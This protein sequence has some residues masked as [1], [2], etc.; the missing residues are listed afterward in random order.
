MRSTEMRNMNATLLLI[1]GSL[2]AT[3]SAAQNTKLSGV[4]SVRSGTPLNGVRVKVKDSNGKAVL[5]MAVTNSRG[6]Y[7]SVVGPGSLVIECEASDGNPYA[8]NPVTEHVVIP[9]NVKS[10]RQDCFFDPVVTTD[11]YWK[12]VGVRIEALAAKNPDK[13]SFYTLQWNDIESANL[14]PSSKAAAAH[15]FMTM[16][17]SSKVNSAMFSD[18]GKVDKF[19]LENAL[20]GDKRALSDLPDSVGKEVL[21][22]KSHGDNRVLNPNQGSDRD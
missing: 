10:G 4:A 12:Q 2:I 3:M 22:Y 6:E 21:V 14:S 18:Y 16:G 19:M 7:L 8:T 20:K 11:T 17:W 13:Q 5:A 15:E 1:C 9:Q